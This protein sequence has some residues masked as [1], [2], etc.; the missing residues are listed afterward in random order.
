VLITALPQKTQVIDFIEFLSFAQFA[1]N[2]IKALFFKG[3]GGIKQSFQQ[4][5]PQFIGT[6]SKGHEKQQL[7][8]DFKNIYEQENDRMHASKQLMLQHSEKI[9]HVA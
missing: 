6:A 4:S 3:F 8:R 1:S 9:T 2:P 7:K 5:Y